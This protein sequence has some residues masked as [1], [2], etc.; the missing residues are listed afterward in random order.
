LRDRCSIYHGG[1]TCGQRVSTEAELEEDLD[2][3]WKNS[4]RLEAVKRLFVKMGA[5]ESEIKAEKTSDV[6]NVVYKKR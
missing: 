4:E 3:P 5:P 6:Q 1:S 2:G